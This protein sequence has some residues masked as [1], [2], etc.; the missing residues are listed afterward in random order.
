MDSTT[1]TA[2]R[3]CV[4][5]LM[6]SMQLLESSISIL[7]AGVNDYPRLAKVLQTTRVRPPTSTSLIVA[8]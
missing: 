4:G 1:A 7:D 3:G 2:L 8:L 6:N 5:S